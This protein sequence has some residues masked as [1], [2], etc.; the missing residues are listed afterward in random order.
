MR[1]DYPFSMT[2]DEDGRL[3][4]AFPDVVGAST[5]GADEAE[6][7]ANA[8][9]CLIAALIGYISSREPIPRPSP[10]RRR[11]TVT[12]SLRRNRPNLISVASSPWARRRRHVVP[13]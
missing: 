5:D 3:V 13:N 6:A 10:P 2:P 9:D 12:R 1:Y 11:S 8:P 7:I 4:V